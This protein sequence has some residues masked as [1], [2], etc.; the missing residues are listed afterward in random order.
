M[1]VAPFAGER[2][3]DTHESDDDAAGPEGQVLLDAEDGESPSHE[4]EV[5]DSASPNEATSLESAE[6]DFRPEEAEEA[7]VEEDFEAVSVVDGV[8]NEALE[9][10][11]EEN[12]A[13]PPTPEEVWSSGEAEKTK[14]S[15]SDSQDRKSE[16][17]VSG[18]S[19]EETEPVVQK[20]AREARD[21]PAPLRLA[22]PMNDLAVVV[23][24]NAPSGWGGR[25][26]RRI[27]DTQ[28][29]IGAGLAPLTLW[30][31]KL[32]LIVRRAAESRQGFFQQASIGFSSGAENYEV[33]V[34]DENG[35]RTANFQKTGGRTLDLVL[36]Y[37]W[38][39]FSRSYAE[40]L[41]GWSFN[42]R[43]TFLQRT[44]DG[45]VP[46][47]EETRNEMEIQT[48]GGVILG[49]TFGWLL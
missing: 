33:L 17:S 30:G 14:E 24:W 45:L 32:S 8:E 48:P 12:F 16:P 34:V 28:I 4:E 36:G 25:Y 21:E 22:E 5:A 38:A 20:E 2:L 23:G 6:L 35:S 10:D 15:E 13:E 31:I 11:F 42:F 47:S 26:L 29:A 3:E 39:V 46:L 27:D 7:V 43:G 18:D 9:A 40:L 1:D 37:R 49:L 41:G 44:G 19:W